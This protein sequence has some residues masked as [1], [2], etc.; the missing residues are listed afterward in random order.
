MGLLSLDASE[1]TTSELPGES[2]DGLPSQRVP[3]SA[4]EREHIRSLVTA[5]PDV[6]IP[7]RTDL[8]QLARTI[9][10]DEE[11]LAWTMVLIGS[12][13]WKSRVRQVPFNRRLLLLPHCMRNAKSCPAT[14]NAEGLLCQHCGACLLGN[15]KTKAE[16]M[17]YRVMIAEGSPVVMQWILSG[18]GDAILGV[19]CLHSLERAFD[20]LVSMGIPAM[21]VPLHASRCRDSQ[22][23]LDWLHEMIDTPFDA[24]NQFVSES[25]VW[26]HLMRGAA[27]LFQYQT[28]PNDDDPLQSTFRIGE[29]Y[30]GRGGKYYRPF[31]TLAAYDALTGSNCTKQ[32]GEK[33]VE[34]LPEW[35]KEMA[36][37]VEVFHKA[38]LIHDDIEDNDD[39][40]YGLPALHCSHGLGIAI[41]T[42][43]FLLG[44]G[45]RII[46]DLQSKLPHSEQATQSEIV[47]EAFRKLSYAHVHLSQG[48]GAEL[49][50][51]Q[52]GLDAVSPLDVL[53]IYALKT[54]PA[55]EVAMNLGVLLALASDT[56]DWPF[57][58][59]S[60]KILARF[61]RH[62]GV[63]FQ[64]YNDLDDWK[65][66]TENKRGAGGDLRQDRPTLI[67][68]LAD[69]DCNWTC[70]SFEKTRKQLLKTKI[71]DKAEQLAEKHLAKATETIPE[72]GHGDLQRL[73]LHFVET[74]SR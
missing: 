43:D 18:Y 9:V 19:G 34:A 27:K 25:P 59:R 6:V 20:K 67:R 49:A 70:D 28:E 45:Y 46:A 53:K 29:D 39:F 55:F 51:Q 63:A 64:I 24:A 15:L 37:A 54:A 71:F 35:V 58:R 22:T 38:S 11:Y 4:D 7:G 13:L 3:Q 32:D 30:L 23:D 41:N 40:R 8:E 31:I 48:Q 69:S 68:A 1:W 74:V 73:L 47:A 60:E 2:L 36:R 66:N 72:I 61:A 65:P 33:Y 57:Y 44:H 50:W 42:G 16:A 26:L 10:D 21:A 14:Y 52:N 12:R 62:V 5:L 17:G 56:V